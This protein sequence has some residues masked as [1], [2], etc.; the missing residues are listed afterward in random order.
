MVNVHIYYDVKKDS[1]L[2]GRELYRIVRMIGK[3]GEKPENITVFHNLNELND[4]RNRK[5]LPVYKRVDLLPQ[6]MHYS[7]IDFLKKK[8]Y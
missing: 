2:L 5:S 4:F 8:Y 6:E 7:F 3:R 1:L